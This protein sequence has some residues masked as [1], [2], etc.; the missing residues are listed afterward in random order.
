MKALMALI[1]VIGLS[2]CMSPYKQPDGSFLVT[3]HSEIRSVFGTNGGFDFVEKCK[4]PDK[5]VMWYSESDF[6]HCEQMALDSNM[7]F[8]KQ[9]RGA[10]PEIVGAAI[11][12]ASLGT[13]AALSGGAKASAGAAATASNIAVQ[14]VNQGKGRH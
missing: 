2:G 3:K 9:S 7:A 6:T 14:T 12:G 8:H 13:G 10:G 11:M 5:K 1:V 4:G